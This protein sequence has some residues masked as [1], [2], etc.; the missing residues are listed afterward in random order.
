MGLTVVGW[1]IRGR[2]GLAR[3]RA[4]DVVA[5]IRRE[6]RDG[7]IVLLHDAP[8]RGDREPAAVRALPAIFEAITAGGLNVVPLAQWLDDPQLEG[9]GSEM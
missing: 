9:E 5:R 2:D 7:A 6:V 4:E 3:A 1:T 8:E